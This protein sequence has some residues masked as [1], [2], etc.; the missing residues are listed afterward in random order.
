VA[1][2]H[3]SSGSPDFLRRLLA[4]AARARNAAIGWV[5]TLGLAVATGTRN[6]ALRPCRASGFAVSA[7]AVGVAGRALCASH[8]AV[9]TGAA[10]GASRTRRAGELAVASGAAGVAGLV[11]RAGELAVAAGATVAQGHGRAP[12]SRRSGSARR[13]RTRR[14]GSSGARGCL[15]LP[16]SLHLTFTRRVNDATG[17]S[18]SDERSE[19][20]AHAHSSDDW[21]VTAGP[22]LAKCRG[23][24]SRKKRGRCRRLVLG[25]QARTRQ[26]AG[27]APHSPTRTRGFPSASDPVD[28]AFSFS[29]AA[30][31]ASAGG[32]GALLESDGRGT[33]SRS[34]DGA[35]SDALDAIGDALDD[36]Q[37][38][39]ARVL[40]HLFDLARVEVLRGLSPD[41]GGLLGVELLEPAQ[42]TPAR[43]F[44]PVRVDVLQS[45]ARGAQH[46]V[47]TIREVFRCAGR[48]FRF[49]SLGRLARHG[50]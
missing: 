18:K 44:D 38:L 8:A 28:S 50:P 23:R 7:R 25:W 30:G 2:G 46:Q 19:P 16:L 20:R 9:A 3:P 24:A 32:G 41:V 26:S 11:R 40:G 47:Q 14:G 36:A 34:R 42:G 31:L 17:E 6:G 10:Q 12:G 4:V 13:W 22:T 27:A 35:R 43:F 33:L 21:P 49:G 5:R 1:R 45:L 39:A 48:G 15:P 29:S 37:K